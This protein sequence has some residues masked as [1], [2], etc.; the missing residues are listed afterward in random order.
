MAFLELARR[1]RSVRAYDSRPV[2]TEKIERCLEAA[3]LAPSASNSQPWHYVIVR[4]EAARASVARQTRLVLSNM[5]RFAVQAPAIAVVLRERPKPH[6]A[7][8]D[9]IKRTR[10]NLIDIGIS[11]AHFCLQA[12][13]EGLGTC[14]IGWFDERGIRALLGIPRRSRP[15]LVLTL[16]YSADVPIRPKKRKPLD[17]IAWLFRFY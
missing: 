12:V 16:G 15:I 3:R 8:G 1:R 9:F 11:A 14:V 10:F 2:E 13:E 17:E 4:D 6:I 5:N 7:A